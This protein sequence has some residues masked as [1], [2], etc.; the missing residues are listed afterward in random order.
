MSEYYKFI[1]EIKGVKGAVIGSFLHFFFL[2]TKNGRSEKARLPFAVA[3]VLELVQSS[4][5]WLWAVRLVNE[6]LWQWTGIMGLSHEYIYSHIYNSEDRR[7]ELFLPCGCEKLKTIK[8]IL[9]T[10]FIRTPV[11][12]PTNAHFEFF[13]NHSWWNIVIENC[14]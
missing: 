3:L 13:N 10:A 4:Q 1:K 2:N 9:E 5:N 12:N 6:H 14:F 8:I 11:L 7:Q